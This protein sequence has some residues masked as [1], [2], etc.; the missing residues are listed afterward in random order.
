MTA[1]RY[2]STRELEPEWG[3]LTAQTGNNTVPETAPLLAVN[4]RLL[5]VLSLTTHP[6]F[7]SQLT[8]M[9]F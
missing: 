4:A 6:V 9:P 3:E 1:S 5:A 8:A 7:S 2:Q